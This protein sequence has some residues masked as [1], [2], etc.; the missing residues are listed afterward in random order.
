MIGPFAANISQRERHTFLGHVP[1]NFQH[2]FCVNPTYNLPSETPAS[3][4]IHFSTRKHQ[5]R[6][7][8]DRTISLSYVSRYTHLSA[9]V[10]V[11]VM[12]TSTRFMSDE[13]L[14]CSPIS[15]SSQ[16]QTFFNGTMHYRS[17][18]G[19]YGGATT[20][21]IKHHC[22]KLMFTCRSPSPAKRTAW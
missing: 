22:R 13:Y 19:A 2:H 11:L 4:N 18:N 8:L 20:L 9:M 12:D 14:L 1:A 6:Q 5:E 16:R 7:G 15:L 21:R 3:C 17:L 10:R